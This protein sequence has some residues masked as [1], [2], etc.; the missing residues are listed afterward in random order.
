M[1]KGLSYQEAQELAIKL[2]N[3]EFAKKE[4]KNPYSGGNVIPTV[5]IDYLAGTKEE[6][7]WVFRMAGPAGPW[8]SI[9]FDFDGANP[10][11]EVGYSWA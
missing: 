4:F 5:K 7:R 6:K 11:V 1:S 10:K 3:E 9:S 2:A 8:A